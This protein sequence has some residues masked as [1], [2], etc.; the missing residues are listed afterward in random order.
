MEPISSSKVVCIHQVTNIQL[1]IS[2]LNVQKELICSFLFVYAH[3]PR[4]TMCMQEPSENKRH[5]VL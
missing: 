3:M 5:Q 4:C 2:I 1:Y